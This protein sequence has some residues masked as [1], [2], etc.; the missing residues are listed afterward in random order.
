MTDLLSSTARAPRQ[1][2]VPTVATILIGVTAVLVATVG[3][4]VA[5]GSAIGGGQQ[6]EDVLPASAIALVKVE[7]APSLSQR[8]AVYDLSR[9]FPRLKA[10]SEQSVRDDLLR[11]LIAQSGERLDYDRDVKPW[12][13]DRVGTAVVPDPAGGVAPVVAIQY[14]DKDKARR[15]LT[16]AQKTNTGRPFAFAFSGD[17]AIV[18]VN[19]RDADR[20]AGAGDRLAGKALFKEGVA[21]LDGE[22]LVLGWA[23]VKGVYAALPGELRKSAQLPQEPAGSFVVGLHAD[24]RYL[25]VRGKAVGVGGSLAQYGAPSFG[26]VRGGNLIATYPVETTAAMELTGLGDSVTNAYGSLAGQPWFG[27]VSRAAKEAGLTLPGD[28]ATLLGTD[29]A[30]GVFGDLTR[31]PRIAAHVKT[32]DPDRAVSILKGAPLAAGAPPFVVDKD[33]GGGYFVAT[34]AGAIALASSGRLGESAPF[35]RALPDAEGASFAVYVSIARALGF[36]G[37]TATDYGAMEAFGMTASGADGAFRMRLTF[38]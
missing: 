12:L 14:T 1:A 15:A 18:A 19:Q 7:L 23:D 5:I 27:Q 33:G 28:L 17:Y 3:S 11:Q 25:E 20:Y 30:V 10:A 26:T 24:S 2:P 16:D 31:S 32:A 35:R 34:D 13:G 8:K 36:A 4:A 21:A 38:R 9:K 37:I 22:Q 29:L 6:P